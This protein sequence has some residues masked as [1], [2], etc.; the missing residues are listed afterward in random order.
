VVY[1]IIS[2]NFLLKL[3]YYY[4]YATNYIAN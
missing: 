2:N 4:L 1:E 3:I